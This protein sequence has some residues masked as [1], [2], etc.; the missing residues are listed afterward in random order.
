MW[1][2][3]RARG[4]LP[5]SSCT[6]RRQRRPTLG[7]DRNPK[8]AAWRGSGTGCWQWPSAFARGAGQWRKWNLGGARR[9]LTREAGE[10]FQGQSGGSDPFSEAPTETPEAAN[11]D[12]RLQGLSAR[13]VDDL[14]IDCGNGDEESVSYHLYTGTSLRKKGCLLVVR[15]ATRTVFIEG[16][17]LKPYRDAVA[18][19]RCA[20]LRISSR[21]E[22]MNAQ[23]DGKPVIRKLRVVTPR[24]GDDLL[25]AELEG[26]E[27]P[28]LA[29]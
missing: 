1:S 13:A 7:K 19:R 28:A 16:E 20:L 6:G 2:S 4:C 25:M 17:R 21:V 3:G 29:S 18:N 8:G 5:P 10:R 11:E 27:P 15:F 22:L 26:Q 24:R 12:E 14:V 9:S 23:K